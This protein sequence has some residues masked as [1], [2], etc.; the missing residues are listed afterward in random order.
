MEWS[1]SSSNCNIC[2]TSFI[3]SSCGSGSKVAAT[4]VVAQTA[5]VM[6]SVVVKIVVVVVEHEVV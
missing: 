6:E 5:L 4:L 1:N 2:S 3:V